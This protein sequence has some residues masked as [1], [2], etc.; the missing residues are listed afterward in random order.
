MINLTEKVSVGFLNQTNGAT[1]YEPDTYQYTY[2][3]SPISHTQRISDWLRLTSSE[4]KELLLLGR[5]W[6]GVA[7][8]PIAPAAVNNAQRLAQKIGQIA[9]N[10][11]RPT[12]TPTIDGQVVLEWH[13][14]T[15]YVDFTVGSKAV[16]VFY[17]DEAE[18]I[19]WEGP[20]DEA[21]INLKVFLSEHCW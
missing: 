13:T 8:Y 12:I 5:G 19:E 16:I 9:P 20:L 7:A 2:F 17:N 1:K 21:P 10:L 3:G 14:D 11:P 18:G 15:H 6:D 4:I